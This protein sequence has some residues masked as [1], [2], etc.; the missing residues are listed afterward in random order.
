[1][2]RSLTHLKNRI[3]LSAATLISNVL[4]P[5][6]CFAIRRVLFRA[7]GLRVAH[8]VSIVGG[9][10]FHFSN[11]SIGEST[12]VGTQTQFV[13]SANSWIHIGANVDVAPGVLFNT[14]SHDLGSHSR[15]AGRTYSKTIT[16]GDGTWIGMG[17]I[18]L[19][20]TSVGDG[21]VIAAG[22]VVRGEFPDDVLIGGMPARVIR[23]LGA[24]EPASGYLASLSTEVC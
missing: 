18:V 17:A 14:G 12:W 5:T 4:P 24:H 16:I 23:Q 13:S 8:G 3:V 19:D 1:M 7:A 15:R 11:V 2:K 6:R 20:G 9:A 21:C 22:A 10:R